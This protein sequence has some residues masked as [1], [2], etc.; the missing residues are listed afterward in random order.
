MTDEVIVTV[1]AT[2]FDKGQPKEPL[3]NNIQNT[4]RSTVP[5]I[6][7]KKIDNLPPRQT[8]TPNLFDDDDDDD[9]GEFEIPDFLKNRNY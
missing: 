7:D 9:D 8:P 1:I 2:G 6:A 5:P 3:Y 4:R